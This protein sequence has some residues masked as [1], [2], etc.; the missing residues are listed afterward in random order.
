MFF[1]R[2]FFTFKF[3]WC[4]ALKIVFKVWKYTCQN[5]NRGSW[6]WLGQRGPTFFTFY[7]YVCVHIDCMLYKYFHNVG[8]KEVFQCKRFSSVPR[9]QSGNLRSPDCR[10]ESQDDDTMG[11]WKVADSLARLPLLVLV[12]RVKPAP[13]RDQRL[14]RES[15]YTVD[16]H[17]SEVHLSK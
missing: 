8:K 11:C 1:A 16:F 10:C 14:K 12:P 4:S 2:L 13:S 9:F 17:D 6:E 15:E 5:L 7:I 3:K